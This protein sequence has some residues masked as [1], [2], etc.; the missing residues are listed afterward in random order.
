GGLFG[1]INPKPASQAASIGC[2]FFTSP[3]TT[4]IFCDTFDQPMGIGNRSGEL[5]GLIWG[6]SRI[7]RP[8]QNQNFYNN[9]AYTPEDQCGNTV[10]VHPPN[11]IHICNG[12]L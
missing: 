7:D 12:L 9:W 6:V 5:N 1:N 4:P 2:Q 10:V 8:N 11:D 3:G